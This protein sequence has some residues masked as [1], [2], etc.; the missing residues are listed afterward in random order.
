M[1]GRIRRYM[2]KP[3]AGAL[4]RFYFFLYIFF[5]G[6]GGANFPKLLLDPHALDKWIG[7]GS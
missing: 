1:L 5:W 7:L 3:K 6:G 4:Q 2:F